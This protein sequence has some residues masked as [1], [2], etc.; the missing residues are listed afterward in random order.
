MRQKH[1]RRRGTKPIDQI[2]IAKERMHLLMERAIS[3]HSSRPDLSRRYFQLSKKIGMRYNVRIHR[4]YKRKFCK[5][6]FSFLG[7]GWRLKNGRMS[8]TC[9]NCGKTM[10]YLYK[11]KK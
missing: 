1:Q 10:R 2:K 7:E 3:M 11:P 4:E 9:K 5:H 8:V 6:C